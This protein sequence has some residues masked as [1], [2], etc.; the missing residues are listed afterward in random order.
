MSKLT[1]LLDRYNKQIQEISLI[2]FINLLV[3]R[4]NS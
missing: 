2:H 4:I 3:H 1:I